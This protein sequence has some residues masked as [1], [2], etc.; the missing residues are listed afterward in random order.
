MDYLYSLYDAL[1][2]I[3]VPNDKARTVVDAME[4]DMGTTIATKSD[5]QLLRQELLAVRQE[6]ATKAEFAEIRQETALL[7][8]DVE[9]LP[10]VMTVR[11][12][13]LLIVGLSLLFA[14][15][16]TDLAVSCRSRFV[17]VLR[18]RLHRERLVRYWSMLA[19]TK[20]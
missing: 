17:P 13:S 5:L 4:R 8:K 16:E 19:L 14:A 11:L 2:S 9:L 20:P 1:V 3:N 12:G 10:T 7:R 15:L 18:L 6:M